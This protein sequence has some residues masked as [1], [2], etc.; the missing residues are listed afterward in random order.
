MQI[1]PY[2]ID[3]PVVLAPMAGV[4]DKPFRLLCKRL[5]AGLAVS[6]MTTADPRLWHTRKSLH[7]DGP[8]RRAGAGQRADRRLRP[9]H[10][11]RGGALQRGQRRAA[12]R[13]QH[14]LSGEESVQR[15][16]RIGAAAGRAAGGAHR[17]G[18][19]GCGGGA[20][21]AEDPH[22]LGSR[23]PQRPEHRPHCRRQ[24]HR[25]AVRARAHPRGQ[26]RGRGRIRHHRRGEG[27]DRYPGVGQRGHHHAAAGPARTAGSPAPTR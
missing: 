6:E 2:R 18:G 13:H 5:G 10:A 1:G 14:G 19:G 9:G 12:D 7:A 25:R 8:R 23:P 21:D 20:G 22:R 26:V 3:P 27:G 16:V 4:T 15:L 17:Q 11:G 24:R